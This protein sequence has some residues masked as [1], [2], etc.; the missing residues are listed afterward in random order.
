MD[1]SVAAAGTT[2]ARKIYGSGD[3]EVKA[4]D[5]VTVGPETVLRNCVIDKNVIVPAGVQI[6]VDPVADAERYT[7]SDDG[8]VVIAKN[9]MVN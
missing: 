6:G 3:T 9:S 8:I 4:L 5:D 2:N 7:V 1:V